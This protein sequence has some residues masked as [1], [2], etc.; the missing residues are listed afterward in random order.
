MMDSDC[1]AHKVA[2]LVLVDGDTSSAG[3]V[4]GAQYGQW[5]SLEDSLR[6]QAS[7]GCISLYFWPFH[8]KSTQKLGTSLACSWVW[9]EKGKYCIDCS[10]FGSLRYKSALL[11]LHL[12]HVYR[13]KSSVRPK[14]LVELWLTVIIAAIYCDIY[15]YIYKIL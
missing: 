14:A 12:L 13:R 15:I 3:Q 4:C 9:A 8:V 11:F 7:S 2:T 5:C 6:L 10:C 1:P